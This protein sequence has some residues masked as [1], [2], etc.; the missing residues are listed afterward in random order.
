MIMPLASA[1]V[2]VEHSLVRNVLDRWRPMDV[3]GPIVSVNG[4][5]DYVRARVLLDETPELCG[6]WKEEHG[7]E[8]LFLVRNGGEDDALHNVI[9]GVCW[10]A[11]KHDEDKLVWMRDVSSWHD[12]R[13]SRLLVG[14]DLDD[15]NRALWYLV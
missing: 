10:S 8:A 4:I 13:T 14:D 5:S 7:H 15:F 3:A 11:F 12:A 2:F 1:F 6:L 9:V